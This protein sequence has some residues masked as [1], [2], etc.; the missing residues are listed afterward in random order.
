M[1]VETGSVQTFTQALEII[2]ASGERHVIIGGGTNLIVSDEGFDGV[3]LKYTADAIS[4][5]RPGARSELA[6]RRR[7]G[8]PRKGR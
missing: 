3:V 5:S 7:A 1:L 4:A 2:R 8:Q 6:T